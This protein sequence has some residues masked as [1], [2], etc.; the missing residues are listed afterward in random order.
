MPERVENSLVVASDFKD[1]DGHEWRQGDRASLA[2]RA[3]RRAATERPEFFRVEYGTEAFDASAPWFQTVVEDY[4]RRYEQAKRQRDEAEERK[5]KALREELKAQKRGQPELERRYCEQEREREERAQRARKALERE[6]IERSSNTASARRDP[7]N[8]GSD[9]GDE[10]H[11][12]GDGV[13]GSA[14]DVP[15]LPQCAPAGLSEMGRSR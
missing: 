1:A 3:V 15:V 6:R 7:T 12:H 2:R 14:R 8:E 4:E 13:G 11:E 10:E 9:D 5:Q